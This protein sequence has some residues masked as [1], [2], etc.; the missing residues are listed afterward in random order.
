MLYLGRE[1]LYEWMKIGFVYVGLVVGD[2]VM[3][4]CRNIVIDKYV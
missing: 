2:I 3:I 1:G 4:I